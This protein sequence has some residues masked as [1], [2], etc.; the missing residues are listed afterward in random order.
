MANTIGA[1]S[2]HIIRGTAGPMGQ[3][4][5]LWHRPGV[6]SPGA[7][8]VGK[9]GT[10]EFI[11][12]HF[13]SQVVLLA[14]LVVLKGLIGTVLSITNGVPSVFANLLLMEVDGGRESIRAARSSLGTFRMELIVRGVR[15]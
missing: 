10:F 3:Q 5:A 7:H 6:D 1:E 14:K 11:A 2:F 8:L 4:V 15:T 9:A 12:I 13:G